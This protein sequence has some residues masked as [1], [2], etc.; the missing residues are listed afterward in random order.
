MEILLSMLL[1]M[2]LI[3]VLFLSIA[4]AILWAIARFIHRYAAGAVGVAA[5]CYIIYGI[6][7]GIAT[8]NAPPV[9]LAPLPGETGEGTYV[10]A[11]DAPAGSFIL[12]SLYVILPLL[13]TGLALILYRVIR[14]PRLPSGAPSS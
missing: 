9:Y 1:I 6:V 14:K 10:F 13:A 5:I 7:D 12:F 11:C 4:Y 2:L 8:C 3:L